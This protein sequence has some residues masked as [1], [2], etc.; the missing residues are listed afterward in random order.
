MIIFKGALTVE[1]R[2]INY[3]GL[4]YKRAHAQKERGLGLDL[5]S[6]ATIL[7]MCL[8]RDLMLSLG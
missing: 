3:S 8:G 1:N 7:L 5:V 6:S 4:T 2:P